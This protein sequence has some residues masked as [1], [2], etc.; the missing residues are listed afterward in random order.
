MSLLAKRC[1]LS[2]EVA[3]LVNGYKLGTTGRNLREEV[4]RTC[5]ENKVKLR[6]REGHIP[7]DINWAPG[8]NCSW[9][10]NI[11]FFSFQ[12]YEP[13]KLFFCLFEPFWTGLSVTYSLNNLGRYRPQSRSSKIGTVTFINLNFPDDCVFTYLWYT[14]SLPP[15]Q[16]SQQSWAARR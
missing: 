16:G 6:E 15:I 9:R 7:E 3:N 12:L 1:L 2:P 10:H 14:S 13:N 8:S 11:G 4:R 5:P